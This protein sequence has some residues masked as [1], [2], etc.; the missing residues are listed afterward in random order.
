MDSQIFKL[1]RTF[2]TLI[3]NISR[4]GNTVL[5]FPVLRQYLLRGSEMGAVVAVEVSEALSIQAMRRFPVGGQLELLNGSKQ[6]VVAVE[7]GDH[8]SIK[9]V[10]G[11][12]VV[13]YVSFRIGRESAFVAGQRLHQRLLKVWNILSIKLLKLKTRYHF[14]NL[15]QTNKGNE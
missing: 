3:T 10:S 12:P 6:A 2:A 9:A 4:L 13:E 11:F 5:R 15:M 8:L 1:K 7:I 14:Y